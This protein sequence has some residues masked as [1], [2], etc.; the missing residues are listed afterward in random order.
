MAE[1]QSMVVK[2]KLNFFQRFRKNRLIK[3]INLTKYNKAPDY[4]KQDD[5]VII[6]L[7]Q[8]DPSAIMEFSE[9]KRLDIL[10]SVPNA[11][12]AMGQVAKYDVIRKE[13]T[14]ITRLSE[15]DTLFFIA[16]YKNAEYTK[17]LSEDFQFRLL[18]E[19][20]KYSVRYR[21][22]TGR[23]GI[24]ERKTQPND[25]SSRLEHF[26]PDVIE[27]AAI[28]LVGLAKK[29][30]ESR[31]HVEWSTVRNWVPLLS[32]MEIDKLPEDT[33]IKLALLDSEFL[34]SM[35]LDAVK[36]FVGKNPMLIADMPLDIQKAL[37]K[38][39]PEIFGMLSR[40]ARRAMTQDYSLRDLVPL[41]ERLD[42]VYDYRGTSFQITDPEV[43]KRE[44]IRYNWKNVTFVSYFTDH[45]K[46][47]A[48]LTELAK[49]EPLVL[50]T[51][52]LDDFV[53]YRKMTHVF[54]LYKE[55]IRNPEVHEELDRLGQNISRMDTLKRN[56]LTESMPK[57]LLNEKVA[58]KVNPSLIVDY[59]RNPEDMGIIRNIVEAAY[60]PEAAKFLEDR[61]G[62][63]LKQIPNLYIFDPVVVEKFGK[64]TVDN[65]LSYSTVSSSVLGDLVRHPD[66]M[67]KF[68][69]FA[70]IVE[71][72]N[73]T[74]LSFDNQLI[75]FKKLEPSFA[76][77]ELSTLTDK[78]KDNLRLLFNDTMM[79]AD[80]NET[81]FVSV[82]TL[83][84]L[85]SYAERRSAMYDEYMK[86]TT[87]PDAIKEALSRRFFGMGY[88]N[89]SGVLKQ[90]HTSLTD[91]VRYYNL[92][93][94][95][96]DE[97]TINSPDFSQ[98][99]LDMLELASIITKINDPVVLKEIYEE[100]SSRDDV[101]RPV[102][103]K[104]VK[105]KIPMQ[106]SKEL[107]D[108]L[109]TI[110]AA[111]Q[112]AENGEQGIEYS[113]R[114]DGVE[115]IKLTGAD[116]RIMLHTTGMN[117]SGL[118]LP[119]ASN[120][121]EL[122]KNFEEGCSTISSCVIEPDMLKSCAV[123]GGTNL[124][125]S[126]VPAKQIVGMSHRDAHVTHSTGVIDPGFEYGAVKYNYPDELVRK[127]A[128]QITG[129]ED[130]DPTHPYNEVAMYRKYVDRENQDTYGQKVMPDYIVVYGPA[131]ESHFKLA[132]SFAGPD[133]KPIPVIEIDVKAYGDRTYMRGYTKENH[134]A[135]REKG[136][137]VEKVNEIKDKKNEE[138]ER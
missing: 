78:Q 98:D 44:L 82:K 16:D 76:N 31:R 28:H 75:M 118:R 30:H 12:E 130:K 54:K 4:L 9:D 55:N 13:P 124:G 38:E 69:E 89:T 40:D 7:V 61:P 68:E 100:L 138:D 33:Q 36:K 64:G 27:K 103:F 99:E 48:A 39:N 65:M 56:E 109:L 34:K 90:N 71:T 114:E 35:S 29:E 113:V 137:V 120:V 125:F 41:E 112:R 111:K 59:L 11:F 79:T 126:N 127:T 107:V 95:I 47:P 119:Y 73:K 117:N 86:K 22:F 24:E 43:C 81:V 17:Y 116:F 108:S 74:A 8:R 53:A 26:S 96:N 2:P 45:V 57:I 131:S 129:Q 104:A 85:D 15:Q 121:A 70:G 80:K 58:Q 91:M 136:A 49:F 134:T 21:D 72:D 123:T 50:S 10:K 5:E 20:N 46:D 88:E 132:K 67:K 19:E 128:A 1:E 23:T 84:D 110:D 51:W 63:T 105:E 32:R 101:L 18:T 133:G 6:A 60:G 52:A 92:E 87:S 106:Y 42:F 62:I 122:W 97:R 77:I 3:K 102:D 135:D 37:V 115:H 93:S 94:F 25:F 66:K 14:Y 83:E